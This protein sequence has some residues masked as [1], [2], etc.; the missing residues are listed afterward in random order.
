MTQPHTPRRSRTPSGLLAASLVWLIVCVLLGTLTFII[1][2]EVGARSMNELLTG[3][4]A[5]TPHIFEELNEQR[6]IWTTV[7][8]ISAMGLIFVL[9][10]IFLVLAIRR[11]VARPIHQLQNQVDLLT[12]GDLHQQADLALGSDFRLIASQLNDLRQSMARERANSDEAD[13]ELRRI[14]SLQQ[15][16]LRELNHRIRNN[17]ASLSSL[18]TISA[19]G[20]PPTADFASRIQRR[21][22]AMASIHGILSARHWSPVPLLEMLNRLSPMEAGSRMSFHGPYLEVAA[23]QATPLAMVLQEMFANAC[24]HGSLGNGAGWLP[25][26]WDVADELDGQAVVIQWRETGGTTPDPQAEAGTGT[27]LIRGLLEGELRGHASLHY[28]DD[29]VSHTLRFPLTSADTTKAEPK[30]AQQPVSN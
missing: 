7:S 10:S 14:N 23:S 18:V 15:L 3:D 27:S 17:L 30:E 6:L 2:S 26:H 21:I 5:I 19:A 29:G 9:M 12:R 11:L 16:M 1:L 22:D 20:E 25:V 4:P 8:V 24:E 28:T 13:V